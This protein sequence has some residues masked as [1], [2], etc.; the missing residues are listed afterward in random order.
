MIT[1]DSQ[2]NFMV[3]RIDDKFETP[4]DISE[5]ENKHMVMEMIL[6]FLKSYGM[7][8]YCYD[9]LSD[10][11]FQALIRIYRHMYNNAISSYLL[12]PTGRI[13]I[14]DRGFSSV[15]QIIV[16]RSEALTAVSDAESLSDIF[17]EHQEPLY[18]EGADVRTDEDSDDE[19][20]EEEAVQIE[21]PSLDE[22]RLGKDALIIRVAK[23]NLSPED[24]DYIFKLLS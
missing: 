7:Y 1:L 13:V 10:E 16:L 15:S 14:R 24:K 19:Y 9:E 21:E 6:A 4:S 11:G 5:D 3:E 23:S 8:R 17:A 18:F 20:S 2:K 22:D 12:P